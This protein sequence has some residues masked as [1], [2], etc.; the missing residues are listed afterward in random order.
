[1]SGK[2]MVLTVEFGSS[3]TVDIVNK[4]GGEGAE[5]AAAG[6]HEHEASTVVDS[7]PRL[8]KFVTAE[9]LPGTLPQE[10]LDVTWKVLKF[11]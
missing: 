8:V 6:E 5:G 1:M 2:H 3:I 4:E 11:A 9:P 10:D 7:S